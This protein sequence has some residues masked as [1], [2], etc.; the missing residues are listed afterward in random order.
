MVKKQKI[1]LNIADDG[2]KNA[3][4]TDVVDTMMEMTEDK[5]M[6][7]SEVEKPKLFT[8]PPVYMFGADKKIALSGKT[9]ELTNTTPHDIILQID[10]AKCV[11]ERGR[12][13]A[14]PFEIFN[15]LKKT[16]LMQRW[17]GTGCLV[18]GRV[19]TDGQNLS[20]SVQEAPADLK[21]D[22]VKSDSGMRITANVT[23]QQS[24]GTI[25]L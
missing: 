25:T 5:P 13:K 6:E 23:Q 7:K 8:R 1:N 21:G 20:A 12:T 4:S 18:E 9:L 16:N 24:A 19:F 2:D 17:L 11:V 22:V 15:K 10:G 14:V 3:P